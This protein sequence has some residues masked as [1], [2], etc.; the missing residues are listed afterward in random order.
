MDETR[1]SR[2]MEDLSIDAAGAPPPT[3][4]TGLYAA[5]VGESM[6][7]GRTRKLTNPGLGAQESGVQ[8][9]VRRGSTVPPSGVTCPSPSDRKKRPS[10]D[11]IAFRPTE[12]PPSIQE[13]AMAS[14]KPSAKP[15]TPHTGSGELS[16]TTKR[17]DRKSV[18]I[19]DVGEGVLE[20]SAAP[21]QVRPRMLK[22]RK[23]LAGAP[24]DH[25]DAFVLSL[26][27]GRITVATLVDVAGMPEAE[28]RAILARL[29]RLGII[30]L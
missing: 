26:I 13:V 16:R 18:R 21:D 11:S 14:Q 7:K 9:R 20:Y 1:G 8:P 2:S 30:A 15:A 24:I 23:A 17:A 12:P 25:R 10:G 3:I 5:V 27:D 28:L 6:S 29:A 4:L 19:D 22:E